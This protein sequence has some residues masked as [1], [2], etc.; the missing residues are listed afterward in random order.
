MADKRI[1]WKGSSLTDLKD[2]KIFTASARDEMG[3]QLREVQR[4]LD[5]QHWKPF[6]EVG[7]GT[8]EIIV[9]EPDGWYRALYVAKFSEAV[10]VLHCFKKKTN[11]TTKHDKNVA[12]QRY[13]DVLFERSKP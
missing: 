3:T 10:Y 6:A 12:K 7:A 8:R 5:P 4:G 1:V 9:D 11:A 2:P 13:Q